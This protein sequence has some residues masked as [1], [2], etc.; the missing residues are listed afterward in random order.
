MQSSFRCR[1][2]RHL[3]VDYPIAR[4]YGTAWHRHDSAGIDRARQCRRKPD[5]LPF[6]R[7]YFAN[8]RQR[9]GNGLLLMFENED[10]PCDENTSFKLFC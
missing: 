6:D 10:K 3:A 1:Q 2:C 5:A 9:D 7:P 8:R 4:L